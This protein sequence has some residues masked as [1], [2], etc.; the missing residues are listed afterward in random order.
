MALTPV[1]CDL[2]RF[3]GTNITSLLTLLGVFY[4]FAGLGMMIG[5]I[6]E[7]VSRRPPYIHAVPSHR[8]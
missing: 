2:M 4:L 8:F 5:A 6:F 3:R 7:F 1:S